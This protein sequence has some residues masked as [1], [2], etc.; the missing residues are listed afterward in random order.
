MNDGTGRWA[1]VTGA[2]AGIGAAFARVLAEHGFGVVL[3]ARRE[4]RLV[5][6]AAEL[7]SAHGVPTEVLPADLAEADAPERMAQTLVDRGVAVDLLVNNAGFG[8]ERPFTATSWE[9]HAVFLQ[10]MVTSLV[11]LTHALLPGMVERGFG[12]VVN[13]ASLAGLIPGTPR[14]TLY[15]PAKAFVVKFSE[16]LAAEH[17][18]DGVHVTALCPGFTYTEFHD[19]V[20]NRA[21]MNEL[22]KWLWMDAD[23]VAREGYAAVMRGDA[24]WVNGLQN[25]VIAALARLSPPALARELLAR[26]KT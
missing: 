5:A 14:R 24:V 1:L 9:D 26:Q 22:P 2:S 18:G 10:V 23:T 17:R 7:S 11:H 20:G 3:S 15:G 25:R 12:R 6:L 8:N 4:E 13:V 19:V 21:Q 16:A